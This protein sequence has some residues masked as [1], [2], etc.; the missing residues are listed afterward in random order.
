MLET[1]A[2]L[3]QPE[4]AQQTLCFICA[5]APPPVLDSIHSHFEAKKIEVQM[6]RAAHNRVL[7][8]VPTNAAAT[9]PEPDPGQRDAMVT[10]GPAREQRQP[11]VFLRPSRQ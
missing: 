6:S 8:L 3:V 5:P 10:W 9:S 7:C 4:C 11:A 1:Q 2:T